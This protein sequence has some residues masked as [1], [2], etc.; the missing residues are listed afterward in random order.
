MAKKYSVV[1]D[2]MLRTVFMSKESGVTI[3]AGDLVAK[4]SNGYATVAAAASTA[5]AYA[6]KGAASTDLK[7]EVTVGNDFV[8]SGTGD[9]AFAITDK[10]SLADITDTTQLIDVSGSSTDVLMVSIANDAGTVGATT[11]IK[12][13]INKPIF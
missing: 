12:V 7:C 2:E 6:P 1:G 8:L 3:A 11:G 4:D 13:K 9:A 10:G 5:V